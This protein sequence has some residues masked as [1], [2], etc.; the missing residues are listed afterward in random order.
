M[1][2]ALSTKRETTSENLINVTIP[3]PQLQDPFN[4]HFRPANVTAMFMPM[5][6]LKV[7]VR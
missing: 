6:L 5:L 3:G 7:G 2:V 1:S 4:D